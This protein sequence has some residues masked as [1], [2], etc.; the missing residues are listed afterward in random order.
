MLCFRFVCD[1]I[2]PVDILVAI[3]DTTVKFKGAK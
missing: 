2:E 1:K 3:T